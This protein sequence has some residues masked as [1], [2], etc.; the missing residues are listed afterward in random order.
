MNKARRIEE[1]DRNFAAIE[2]TADT[3]WYDLRYLG[4]ENQAFK[5]VAAPYD[6]LPAR[7][8]KLVNLQASTTFQTIP[9]LRNAAIPSRH[10]CSIP[11]ASGPGWWYSQKDSGS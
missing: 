6:R 5:E 10:A 4:I 8:E 2:A 1:I 7:A 9:W 3:A 11:G